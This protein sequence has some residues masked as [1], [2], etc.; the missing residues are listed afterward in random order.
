[1]NRPLAL[2]ALALLAWVACDN[3]ACL[4]QSDLFADYRPELIEECCLCLARRGTAFPE[5]ACGEASITLDGG[6]LI[7]VDS[8]PQ[9]PPLEPGDTFGGDDND[10]VIDE[11]EIPCLCTGTAA[12]CQAALTAGR[13]IIVTGACVTQGSSSIFVRAPCEDA[14]KD[15]LTF[16][17]PPAVTE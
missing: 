16:S 14:C 12:T 9:N 6:V 5:A 8:G 13:D 15:V 7:P 11:S 3:R 17:P 2:I 1:M 4:A 10:D